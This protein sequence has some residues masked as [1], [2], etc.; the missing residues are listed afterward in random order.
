MRNSKKRVWR[1]VTLYLQTLLVFLLVQNRSQIL[2]I[3][4]VPESLVRACEFSTIIG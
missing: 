1:H 3:T 4:V 2:T